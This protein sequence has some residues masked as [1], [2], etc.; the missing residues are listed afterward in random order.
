MGVLGWRGAKSQ[1]PAPIFA[2]LCYLF[3]F[4]NFLQHLSI[5]FSSARY[6]RENHNSICGLVAIYFE[7]RKTQVCG[8]LVHFSRLTTTFFFF[9]MLINQRSR[10]YTQGR[11]TQRTNSWTKSISYMDDFVEFVLTVFFSSQSHFSFVVYNST[12]YLVF[13]WFSSS[14]NLS[15][16]LYLSLFL[17]L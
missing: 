12:L 11:R 3:F 2:A 7:D 13:H 15:L 14:L 8:S 16:S 1:R 10:S 17:F 5:K 9:S 6:R 4:I